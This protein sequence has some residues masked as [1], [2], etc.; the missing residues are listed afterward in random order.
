MRLSLEPRTSPWPL[1][2]ALAPLLAVALATLGAGILFALMG[3]DPLAALHALFLSPLDSVNGLAELALKATPLLLCAIGIAIGVRANVWN[4][5]AEGQFIIGA[6]C[7][8]GVALYFGPDGGWWLLPLMLLAG[9]AGGMAWAAVAAFLRTRFNAHE[10]LV[11]LMLSYTAVQVL[12]WLVHGP[13]QDP[14]GFNFPQTPLF[15]PGAL[16]PVLIEGTRVNL[17]AVFALL[18]VPLGSLLLGRMM[19]GFR[20]RV[21]GLAPGAARYAGFSEAGTVW[22]CLLLSGGLAGLAGICEVAGPIGQLLPVISPGYGFAAI[23]V[24]FLGRLHPVGILFAAL[25][26]A[27]LYLGG[28]GLQISQQLPLAVTGVIQGMLLFFLLGADV[29]IGYRVRIVPRTPR[30]A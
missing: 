19:V 20:I 26:M 17:G 6:I 1:M 4:I 23:I 27:L 11:T 18:S 30:H 13:W 24:A 12:G 15:E 16:L 5:G 25:L 8:G 22:F 7:G 28:E 29:F 10:I 14:E 9:V 21:V 3:R 2:S